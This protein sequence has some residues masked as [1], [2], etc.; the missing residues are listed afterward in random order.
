VNPL[1]DYLVLPGVRSQTA[2]RIVGSYDRQR[3][4]EPSKV[5][6]M[7]R[8]HGVIPSNQNA[9][10]IHVVKALEHVRVFEAFE[11]KCRDRLGCP[12]SPVELRLDS[13]AQILI[14]D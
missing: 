14:N 5:R 10:R 11:S 13:L 8:G 1:L 9:V 7:A 3:R 6:G 2:A 4:A 12:P